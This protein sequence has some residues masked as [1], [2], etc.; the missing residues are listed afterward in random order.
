[1]YS[2]AS[3]SI[4]HNT[5]QQLRFIPSSLLEHEKGEWVSLH[6]EIEFLPSNYYGEKSPQVN[7]QIA[8]ATQQF[9]SYGSSGRRNSRYRTLEEGD[10]DA[11]E[12]EQPASSSTRE[13][14]SQ[15]RV[16]PFVE[17]V[18][19]YDA[20]QQAWRMLGFMI[21]CNTVSAYDQ[22]QNNN[23][24]NN[25]NGHSNDNDGSSDGCTRYVLWAAVSVLLFHNTRICFA[26][27]FH[28][29]CLVSYTTTFVTFYLYF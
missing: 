20:Y 6:P 13:D 2:D 12:E 27:R 7:E 28:C 3:Q 16:Q 10:G 19:D 8:T 5:E 25:N 21:D 14:N 9:L 4:H 1:M 29:T 18:S 24:N 22:S 15:Y 17:G 26:V 23:N 11:E